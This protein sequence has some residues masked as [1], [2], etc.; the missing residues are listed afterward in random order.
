[1]QLDT[2]IIRIP[3]LTR[4]YTFF[5]TSDC[6]I[7]HAGPDES[8]EAH[9][10]ADRETAF[11]TYNNVLPAEAMKEMLETV[12][13]ANA[14]GLFL[15]G[16]I[17]DYYSKGTLEKIQKYLDSSS[18]ELFYVCG[19]HERSFCSA[20]DKE[21]RSFYRF[22]TGIMHDSPALWVHDFGEFLIVG[23]DD[24]DK[25]I[26]QE[27]LDGLEKLFLLGK[28]ILLLLHIPI[29]TE[30]L[31]PPVTAKFPELGGAYFLLG[32]SND[33]E[34]SKRFC[35]AVKNP[36]NPIAAVF[37]G[38]IHLSHASEIAPGRMQYTSAPCYEGVIRKYIVT[39]RQEENA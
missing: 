25:S 32:E 22:Y 34:I 35:E 1:M 17:A 8:A 29:T 11:W 3:G 38:H 27:Q 18:T 12:D 6:H 20:E 37:A 4:D 16:D 9:E 23:V 15:C 36:C 30:A 24:G 13:A 26:R 33:S 39:G 19:N 28:P 5:H 14:D 31:I 2:A 10:L 21:S 7:A